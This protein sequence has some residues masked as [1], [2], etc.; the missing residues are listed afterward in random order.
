MEYRDGPTLKPFKI[1]IRDFCLKQYTFRFGFSFA[2][3]HSLSL[4]IFLCANIGYL[5]KTGV[6]K[7]INRTLPK[8]KENNSSYLCQFKKLKEQKR[9]C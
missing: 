6:E 3:V 2:C 8:G 5:G 1:I 7:S 9:F 4:N